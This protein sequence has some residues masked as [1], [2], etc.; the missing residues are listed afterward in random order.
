M[1][2]AAPDAASP[3]ESAAGHDL[4]DFGLLDTD[5]PRDGPLTE[6]VA[7]KHFE[8][9]ADVVVTKRGPHPFVLPQPRR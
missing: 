4:A 8:Q 2:P 9:V 3:L 6:L 1:S 7:L 5:H